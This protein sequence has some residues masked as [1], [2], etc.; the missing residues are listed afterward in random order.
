MVCGLPS[1]LLFLQTMFF[2][3][4]NGFAR[5]N[6]LHPFGI[7]GYESGFSVSREKVLAQWAVFL[8]AA[9]AGVQW[10]LPP[11]TSPSNCGPGRLWPLIPQTH[12]FTFSL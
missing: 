8:T 12:A 7:G 4:E 11:G 3:P 2:I 6:K 9:V 1:W 10:Q 5:M